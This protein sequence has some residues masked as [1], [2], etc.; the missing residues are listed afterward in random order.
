MKGGRYKN[1]IKKLTPV[2]TTVILIKALWFGECVLFIIK[3]A[4]DLRN[5]V[6]RN[7]KNIMLYSIMLSFKTTISCVV[8]A[9]PNLLLLSV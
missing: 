3:K 4:S 6:R 8:D 1:K 5:D 9:Q 7:R 2:L